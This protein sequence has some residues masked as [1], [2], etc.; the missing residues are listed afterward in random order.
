M[1]NVLFIRC[2]KLIC[3]AWVIDCKHQPQW[4]H[5]QILYST[6]LNVEM[7]Y[8]KNDSSL[9]FSHSRKSPTLGSTIQWETRL[10]P[11]VGISCPHWTPM[12]DS[13]YLTYQFQPVGKTKN[14]QSHAGNTLFPDV[15]VVLKMT[16]P[17]R[18]LAYSGFL[19]AF[20]MFFFAI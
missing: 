6:S 16:S 11:R 17:C 9:L 3:I 2:F 7:V 5:Q 19:E 10:G 1:F 15:I 13:I 4:R 20:F 14:E 12:M 18:I 8:E